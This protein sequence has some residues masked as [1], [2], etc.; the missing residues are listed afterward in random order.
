V[1]PYGPDQ[2]SHRFL[3]GS[4][5]T[6]EGRQVAQHLGARTCAD[7]IA[8]AGDDRITYVWGRSYLALA[9]LYSAAYLSLV[10]GFV[11]ALG[12]TDLGQRRSGSAT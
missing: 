1:D 6:E 5:Y 7:V 9:G 10:L 11:L 2:Q 3:V 12:A 8:G 4:S